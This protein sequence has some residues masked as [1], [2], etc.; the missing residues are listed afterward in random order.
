MGEDWKYPN[1]DGN[2]YDRMWLNLRD[3]FIANPEL[4]HL[5]KKLL[6]TSWNSEEDV[7]LSTATECLKLFTSVEELY[8]INEECGPELSEGYMVYFHEPEPLGMQINHFKG[9]Q[10]QYLRT[11]EIE[12]V[13]QLHEVSNYY[14]YDYND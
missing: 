6:L 9:F 10:S 8:I 13:P 4:V 1:I 7:E 11:L 14:L 12:Y 3:N 2:F 5:T